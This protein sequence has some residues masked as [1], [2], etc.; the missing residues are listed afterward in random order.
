MNFLRKLSFRDVGVALKR[1]ELG[2]AL[3]IGNNLCHNAIGE[4]R[5][6]FTKRASARTKRA[7]RSAA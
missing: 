7:V 1:R 6:H 3:R 4:A 5:A 2:L